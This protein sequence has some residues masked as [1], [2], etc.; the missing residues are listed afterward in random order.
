VTSLSSALRLAFSKRT[1]RGFY[2][3]AESFFNIATE[4]DQLGED[5]VAGYG[6]ISLHQQSH[7]ESFL[8]LLQNRFGRKGFYILDEPEAALSPQR[9]L[10]MLAV[11]RNLLDQN[12]EIQFLIATHSPI[13]LAY[14]DAQILS[15]D[16]GAIHETTWQETGAYQVVARFVSRPEVYLREIFGD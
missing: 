10:T 15:F 1:G 3:R 14:P 12:D 6:G 7:G 4:V 2:L 13:L 8:A 11:L 5:V 16:D 9:Q